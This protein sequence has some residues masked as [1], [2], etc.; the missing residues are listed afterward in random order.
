VVSSSAGDVVALFVD[1]DLED[2]D[3]EDAPA[4]VLLDCGGP[5]GF[6]ARGVAL[7]PDLGD[8]RALFVTSQIPGALYRCTDDGEGLAQD[9]ELLTRGM[10][11]S[12]QV[13]TLTGDDVLVTRADRDAIVRACGGG[14]GGWDSAVVV[15][16]LDAAAGITR[17]A[18]GRILVT[19]GADDLVLELI[20]AE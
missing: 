19:G 12:R 16:G 7:A 20:L 5:M 18:E 1:G 3:P 6:D 2:G 10:N 11:G 14:A 9:G 4:A 17:T 8:R 15:T 13:L